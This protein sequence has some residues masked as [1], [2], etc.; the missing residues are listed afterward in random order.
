M[1]VA[2]AF[3]AIASAQ[4]ESEE[5]EALVLFEDSVVAYQEGRF[6]DAVELLTR[7]YEMHPEPVLLYNLARA[8][9]GG[10]NFADAVESYERY[11][12]E[13]GDIPDRGA[14]EQRVATLRANLDERA[15]LGRLDDVSDSAPA[16]AEEPDDGPGV[17]P[18]PWVVV[19]VGAVGIGVGAVLGVMALGAHDE[20]LVAPSQEET[21]DAQSRAEGLAVGS[22]IAF[23]AGGVL[24]A[25]GVTWG[26]ISL[27]GGGSDAAPSA[28]L[29]IVPGGVLVDG[30]F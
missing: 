2:L 26:I 14:I 15:R 28:Q 19:G 27:A 23:I 22:T 11:L 8:E 18:L 16:A 3:P 20:A 6:D 25:A 29:R 1:L 17:N 30:R 4:G 24:V 10:G 12:F 5:R 9:D 13:A 7:A 21:A